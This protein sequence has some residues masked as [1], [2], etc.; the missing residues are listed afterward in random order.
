M[1]RLLWFTVYILLFLLL[2]NISLEL[3]AFFITIVYVYFSAL[4][5]FF[6]SFGSWLYSAV[7]Q[8]CSLCSLTCQA[9]RLICWPAAVVP[10]QNMIVLKWHRINVIFSIGFSLSFEKVLAKKN[11]SILRGTWLNK[12]KTVVETNILCPKPQQAVAN[13]RLGRIMLTSLNITWV[14]FRRDLELTLRSAGGRSRSR[15]TKSSWTLFFG[16]MRTTLC[17]Q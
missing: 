8:V 12:T 10:F 5:L 14:T 4:D 13:K 7:V 11:V 6:W 17:L 15:W 9:K 16:R 2:R 3:A 1:S